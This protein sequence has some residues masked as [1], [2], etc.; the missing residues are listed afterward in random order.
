VWSDTKFWGQL[1]RQERKAAKVLG[2]ND[3]QWDEAT[4]AGSHS[5]DLDQNRQRQQR[6]RALTG[7]K[8]EGP[9]SFNRKSCDKERG[10]PYYVPGFMGE[11]KK[12]PFGSNY[13]SLFGK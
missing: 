10:Q 9:F 3:L 8:V 13:K 7:C 6:L 12:F 5:E 1:N 11:S 4:R 2:F